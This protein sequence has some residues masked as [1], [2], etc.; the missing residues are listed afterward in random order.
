[1]WWTPDVSDFSRR[2]QT[3]VT[4]F[5]RP[6]DRFNIQQ[7]TWRG[8][9]IP[10][11]TVF[12]HDPL[13]VREIMWDMHQSSFRLDLTA[14]DQYLVPALWTAH[15]YERLDALCKIFG[16]SD[17]FI[18][19]N[20]S[21]ED[22]GIAASDAYDRGNAYAAFA[23][24]MDSWTGISECGTGT[25]DRR[26]PDAIAYRYCKTFANTFGR[27]PILPKMVPLSEAPL[28]TLIRVDLAPSNQLDDFDSLSI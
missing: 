20:T 27:P 15:K 5:G 24:L 28:G 19:D 2:R 22:T 10:W 9:N 6:P 8:H 14:L 11:G 18:L 21:L 13:L 12:Q 1:M 4:I 25:S 16:T 7:A 17:A 23:S 3:A 26:A